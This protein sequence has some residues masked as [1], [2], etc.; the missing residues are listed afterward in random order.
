MI[1]ILFYTLVT[2]YY[3]QLLCLRNINPLGQEFANLVILG[4]L[5]I[6]IKNGDK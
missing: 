4:L 5:A 2:V 1:H 3:V 6:L